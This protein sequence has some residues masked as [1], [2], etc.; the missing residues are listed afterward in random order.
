MQGAPRAV[1]PGGR[2]FI[3]TSALGCSEGAVPSICSTFC[4]LNK[5]FSYTSLKQAY[6]NSPA[7]HTQPSS[8]S[9]L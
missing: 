1:G 7:P 3:P 8:S 9:F 4:L 6:S 5:I 2:E